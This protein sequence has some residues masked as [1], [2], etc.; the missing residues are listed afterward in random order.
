MKRIVVVVMLVNLFLVNSIYAQPYVSIRGG[1]SL[2]SDSDI[3]GTPAQLTYDLGYVVGGA[4]GYDFGNL[5]AEGE[6]GY[7]ENDLDALTGP[8]GS[9][10]A[11]GDVSILSFMA[12]G[13]FEHTFNPA[14]EGYVGFGMGVANA[15]LSGTGS[16]DD[17]VFAYQAILGASFVVNSTVSAFTEYR[18]LGTSDPNWGGTSVDLGGHQFNLGARIYFN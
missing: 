11:N 5:R 8:G 6:I 16:V 3:G 18:Y 2:L 13:Y 1:L 4:F 14:I 12:N 7:S 10:P 15:E 17:T 9:L